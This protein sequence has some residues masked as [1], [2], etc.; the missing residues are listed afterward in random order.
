MMPTILWL[1]YDFLSMKKYVNVSSKSNKPWSSLPKIAGSGSGSS[2]QRLGTPDLVSYQNATDPQHW[3]WTTVCSLLSAEAS[4][5]AW[6]SKKYVAIVVL[7]NKIFSSCKICSFRFKTL[8][9]NPYPHWNQCGS[10]TPMTPIK[11][12]VIK[13]FI[14]LC[15][16]CSTWLYRHWAA[17]VWPC[18]SGTDR[19]PRPLLAASARYLTY[20]LLL[21][22]RIQKQLL[23]ILL[24]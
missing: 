22:Q 14:F 7:K 21:E 4:P 19:R 13:I 3:F 9:I 23:E 5:I 18:R 17:W 20:L 6:T 1:L 15:L 8:K 10:K 16:L 24:D 12:I 11:F 2:S